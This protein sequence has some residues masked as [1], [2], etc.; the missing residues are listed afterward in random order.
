M[1]K[2]VNRLTF[3]LTKFVTA[4]FLLTQP[5][6]ATL[7]AIASQ[8]DDPAIPSGDCKAGL[9]G[10]SKIGKFGATAFKI[11]LS[12]RSKGKMLD[13]AK[14]HLPELIPLVLQVAK[15]TNE[16][17]AEKRG[18]PLYAERAPELQAILEEI[19]FRIKHE[20]VTYQWAFSLGFRIAFFSEM[21]QVRIFSNDEKDYHSGLPEALAPESYKTHENFVNMLRKIAQADI[22]EVTWPRIVYQLMMSFP[23]KICLS[24]FANMGFPSMNHMTANDMFPMG[25]VKSS[26]R[27]ALDKHD[28]RELGHLI[29]DA[30]HAWLDLHAWH[31]FNVFNTLMSRD[32]RKLVERKILEKIE[33]HSGQDFDN[34][35]WQQ[36]VVFHEKGALWE[37]KL[38]IGNIEKALREIRTRLMNE[39]ALRTEVLRGKLPYSS[40]SELEAQLKHYYEMYMGIVREVAQEIGLP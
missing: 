13:P 17:L 5:S 30:I 18:K 15:K 1:N 24:I 35:S 31:V 8:Q 38:G 12:L 33:R 40:D 9:S 20:Q 36:Y 10:L 2:S 7:P 19:D 4:L 26:F 14:T 3:W 16:M 29:H 37:T 11:G 22:E 28:F 39:P 34:L 32:K 25:M 23:N 27:G 21:D 6:M